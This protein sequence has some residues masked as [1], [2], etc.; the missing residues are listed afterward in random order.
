MICD[1]NSHFFVFVSLTKVTRYVTNHVT[2]FC[3]RVT[4]FD[5]CPLT[6]F[7][8]EFIK[9]LDNFAKCRFYFIGC[10]LKGGPSNENFQA[11][12]CAI[13]PD[14]GLKI[15]FQETTLENW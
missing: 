4:E 7:Y 2:Y 14:P 3:D 13:M 5:H 8:L 1:K 12:Q 10:N 11:Q 15:G 9:N 6:R